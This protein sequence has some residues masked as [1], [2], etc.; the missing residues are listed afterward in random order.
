MLLDQGHEAVCKRSE[1]SPEPSEAAG[2]ASYLGKVVIPTKRTRQRRAKGH[3]EDTSP[4]SQA[5]W[6]PRDGGASTGPQLE[7][8]PG[9]LE[10][11]SS[12]V[13]LLKR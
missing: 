7:Q 3:P 5:P 10:P 9:R 4:A 1:S 13:W 12:I 8:E 6:L 2:T 11:G